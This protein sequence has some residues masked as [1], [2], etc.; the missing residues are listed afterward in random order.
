M[1]SRRD[2]MAVTAATALATGLGG[3]L[4]RAAAAQSITQ[5]ELLKFDAKGQVT[6]VHY[7]DCHAQIKPLYFREPSINLGVG[8]VNG[9]PPHV[10]GDEFI[11][12]FGLE[13]GSLDAYALTYKDF[14]AMA[15]NYGKLGGT[16]RMATLLNA[17]RAERPDNT[18]FLDGGDTLHGSYTALKSGGGDMIRLLNALKCEA[19]VGHWEF[20]LGEDRVNEAIEEM[21]FPFLASNVI[22][23][24]WEEE[25]F[26]HTQMFERGGIKVAVIGQA[27]PYTPIAN[28]RWMIPSWSFGVRDDIMQKR[29]D[30]ARED[31][32]ELIVVLSHN[33]FD[34]DR[35][36]ASNV[37]GIDI[38]LTGHT[39]DAIP[40]PIK[41]GRTLLIATGSHGKF[42]SR[43]DVEVSGGK[44]VDA[45]HKLIPVLSDAIRPDP[46]IK[47]LVDEIRAP[48][49]DHLGTV[50]GHTES[51]LYRRGNFN[52]TFDDLICQAM[53]EERDAEL[54]FSPGVRWGSSILPGQPITWDHVYNMTAI[55][56]PNCYRIKMSGEN[57]KLVLEDVADNLFNPDPYLQ[58]GGDMVRVGGLGYTIDVSKQIGSRI[59]DMTLLKTGKPIDAAREYTVAGW[60]SVNEGTEGPPIWDVVANYI[61]GQKTIS[62]SPNDSIKVHGG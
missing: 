9:K 7:T 15:S 39:H 52:G 43:I 32:A 12:M 30:A 24:E 46:E 28:P 23:T 58:Q 42:L 55:T 33:G 13:A 49:E 47:A 59:S 62:L 53:L 14:V 27:F 19:M 4:G 6:L 60:A 26:P 17:I 45:A 37:S 51:L 36:M 38:I 61:K 31:G 50:L 57:L 34:V 54:C 8:D 48:H 22:D 3:S 29:V 40:V 20:T 21:N 35:K 44:M 10:T 16:D 11:K 41:V 5:D 18:I 25:V 1:I 56:Y 2:F